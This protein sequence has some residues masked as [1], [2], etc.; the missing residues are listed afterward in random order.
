VEATVED[1]D[2]ALVNLVEEVIAME[3][4]RT[5]ENI[6]NG[7]AR[8]GDG[9]DARIFAFADACHIGCAASKGLIHNLYPK[10]LFC[11]K[12]IVFDPLRHSA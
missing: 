10:K 12:Y 2:V 11:R 3:V 8:E 5:R 6:A 9:T 1:E 4:L 7:Y